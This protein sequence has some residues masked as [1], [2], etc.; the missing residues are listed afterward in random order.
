MPKSHPSIWA[1]CHYPAPF[2]SI[3]LGITFHLLPVGLSVPQP[4][5]SIGAL[6]SS[7]H[8][9][10]V[11]A[12]SLHPD[13]IIFRLP[14]QGANFRICVMTIHEQNMRDISLCTPYFAPAPTTS[15]EPDHGPSAGTSLPHP[16]MCHCR[17]LQMSMSLMTSGVQ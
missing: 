1:G 12:T 14:G 2:R 8:V 16:I 10:R 6:Q 5:Q 9:C 7:L 11:V 3:R 13:P 17:L 15:L 4:I